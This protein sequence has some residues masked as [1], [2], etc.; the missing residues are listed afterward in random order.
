MRRSGVL[1][2]RTSETRGSLLCKSPLRAL[3]SCGFQIVSLRG[4]VVFT[5][6][7]GRGREERA[8]E[9]SG[10]LPELGYR[11]RFCIIHFMALSGPGHPRRGSWRLASPAGPIERLLH[12][13]AAGCRQAVRST[14]CNDAPDSR[15]RQGCRGAPNGLKWRRFDYRSGIEYPQ[16][17]FLHVESSLERHLM[18]DRV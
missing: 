15:G 17:P 11:L 10:R 9:G 16:Y 3:R 18:P 7:R 12:Q 5:S 1:I 2:H 4:F 13:R 6:P 14:E 8:G